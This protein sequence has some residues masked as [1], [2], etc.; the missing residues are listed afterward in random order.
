MVEE[1]T[2][3]AHDGEEQL[4]G[5]FSILAE[6]LAVPFETRVLGVAV[7]VAGIGQTTTGIVAN[8]VRGKHR[9]AI[10]LIDLPLPEPPPQGAE[11]I[12][13]YQLWAEWS[14]RLGDG[15][16]RDVTELV[17]QLN[18]RQA[19]A[20]PSSPSSSSSKKQSSSSSSS[21]AS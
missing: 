4:M 16:S 15:G 21:S 12:V 19:D 6:E 18:G 8:C 1:A 3:D 2:I 20:S 14:R 11:W 10:H 5:F 9:Q 13:A 7:T 17:R